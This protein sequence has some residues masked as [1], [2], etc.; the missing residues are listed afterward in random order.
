MHRWKALTSGAARSDARPVGQV[1]RTLLL[2]ADWQP[3]ALDKLSFDL[4]VRHTSRMPATRDNAVHL[5]ARTLLDVGARY[6]FAVGA[7]PAVLRLSLTN[8]T[9]EYG[10]DLRGSGAY[11]TIPGRRASAYVTVDW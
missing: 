2:N 3:A 9:D 7:A 6:R 10:Y 5:P 1:K 8:A 4:A 11:D